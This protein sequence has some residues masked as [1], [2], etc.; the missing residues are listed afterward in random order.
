M[1]WIGEVNFLK[2]Y[3]I[4]WSIVFMFEWSKLVAL[5]DLLY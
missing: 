2:N 1:K 3:I 4:K 5:I